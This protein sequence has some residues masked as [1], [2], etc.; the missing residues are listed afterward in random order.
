[1]QVFRLTSLWLEN[2]ANEEVHE[3]LKQ[4]L[5][6]IPSYKFLSVL[7]QL[8]PRISNNMSDPFASELNALL[9][10]FSEI[11]FCKSESCYN[12]IF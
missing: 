8:A 3:V 4:H 10:K 1:L 9:R 7:P 12:Y 2:T 6:R 11:S 5:H